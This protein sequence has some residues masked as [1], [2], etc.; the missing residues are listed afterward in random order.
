MAGKNFTKDLKKI[1]PNMILAGDHK[2]PELPKN[3]AHAKIEPE[4]TQPE[5]QQDKSIGKGGKKYLRLDITGYQNYISL[6]AEHLTNTSGRY[7][8][9][10]QYILRLIEADK[11]SNLELFQKLEQ[12]EN[13]KREII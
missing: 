6:M 11:Q 4:P 12:I 1:N 5:P 8:S 10:T 13:L 2:E 7:V 9:M 3:D